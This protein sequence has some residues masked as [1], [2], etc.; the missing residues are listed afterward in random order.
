LSFLYIDLTAVRMAEALREYIKSDRPFLGI[1]LG[2]QLLFDYSEENGPG[3]V[4]SF[5]ISGTGD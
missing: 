1:C 3:M 4:P 5:K 2:L